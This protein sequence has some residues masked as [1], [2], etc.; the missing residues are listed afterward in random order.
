MERNNEADKIL[1][2]DPNTE[3]HWQR[4]VENKEPIN[5]Q[6]F[7]RAN[8][9]YER[10]A[11][12]YGFTKK[13]LP[14]FPDIMPNGPETVNG[15]TATES[16]RPKEE[17]SKSNGNSIDNGPSGQVSGVGTGDSLHADGHVHSQISGDTTTVESKLEK[18]NAIRVL[19]QGKIV[20]KK[21]QIY[22]DLDEAIRSFL[23]Q[24]LYIIFSS[25]PRQGQIE[26]TQDEI[27]IL[28]SIA[29]RVQEKQGE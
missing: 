16:N 17:R 23:Q 13:Q 6:Q 10:L 21:G 14:D 20:K 27:A 9:F 8:V 26:L 11:N 28:K 24:Q 1:M 22:Y 7:G 25:E 3:A 19:L 12:E 18:A 4:C 2:H 15:Q 5:R 29:Q